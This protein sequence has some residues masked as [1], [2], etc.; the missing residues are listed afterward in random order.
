LNGGYSYR[1]NHTKR[2]QFNGPGEYVN[3]SADFDSNYF[4]SELGISY[5]LKI[6][7]L[8]VQD[9]TLVEGLSIQPLV[10]I[11]Y[12]REEVDGYIEDFDSAFQD[13]GCIRSGV[14]TPVDPFEPPFFQ[15][16][17]GNFVDVSE[18]GNFPRFPR[19]LVGGSTIREFSSQTIESIPL[20]VGVLISAQFG[21]PE[22][23][24]SGISVG[25]SYTHDFDDQKR[26][27]E[28]MSI[29]RPATSVE[30]EERNRNR[31][32]LSVPFALRFN[33]GLLRGTFSYEADIGFDERE[34][35]DTFLLQVRVPVSLAALGGG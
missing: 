19:G 18:G 13:P 20:K 17:N 16:C 7:K 26:T 9:S 30:Y 1:K 24:I 6:D 35:A 23:G 28:A 25:T 21:N 34:R 31:N 8:T 11:G 5:N 29:D 12:A 2:R 10:S 32:Y 3:T 15:I 22:F 33:L 4:S 27:V 14:L